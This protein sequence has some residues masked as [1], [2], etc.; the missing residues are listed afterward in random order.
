M[1]E[2][3]E[4]N[5]HQ[6]PIDILLVEDNEADIKI[7][8]RTFKKSR[9]ANRLFVV[10]DGQE[11]LDYIFLQGHYQDRTA[12]PLPDLILLDINMPKVNGFQVLENLKRNEEFKYIPVVILTTSQQEEDIAKSY[13]TGACSFISKPI[14]YEEFTKKIEA[15]N[16]YWQIVNILPPKKDSF[17]TVL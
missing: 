1:F 7:T 16:Y 4:N 2:Y 3:P 10:R 11:A 8:I 17:H 6:K 14:G 5:Q 13:A 9:L 12:F 15:F